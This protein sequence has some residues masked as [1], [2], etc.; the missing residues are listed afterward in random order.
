[1]IDGLQQ[2]AER[3]LVEVNDANGRVEHWRVADGIVDVAPN[4]A[5][6]QR[7]SGGILGPAHHVK[8]HNLRSRKRPKLRASTMKRIVICS[9]GTWQTPNQ[10]NATHVL[11]MARAVLPTA[12][13]GTTQVVFYDWGVGTENWLNRL[14]GGISGKGIDK[15][16]RDCYRF[17]AHNYEDGDEIYL[18][19]F[20]RGAY[21]VRSLAGL[22]RNCGVLTKAEAGR[23]PEAYTMYRRHDAGPNSEVA[24]TFRSR[25]SREATVKFIGVWDTVG[26]LGIPL[27]GLSALTAHRYK[28]HDVKLSS[29]VPFAYHALAIDERRR[30]FRPSLW[31]AQTKEGQTVEQV[32]FAGVHSDVGGS[33]DPVLGKPSFDWMKERASS[34]G[35][36]LDETLASPAECAPPT[37]KP[38]GLLGRTVA[39]L[40]ERLS[41]PRPIGGDDT[42]WVHPSALDHYASSPSGAP[43]NLA[44]YLARPD[45]RIYGEER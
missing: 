14:V 35:L 12:P 6:A 34:A 18:F 29:R 21:T 36:A 7:Q 9:D 44:S 42:Q 26:A 3:R 19:G 2:E 15:N 11:E 1:M 45:A 40:R 13:D 10:D 33:L 20:S 25:N 24:K 31:E 16:I 23:L 39:R 22:V 32:W 30:P 43:A 5:T 8:S 17:L 4:L 41:Q 38:D 28:F 37:S 27:C